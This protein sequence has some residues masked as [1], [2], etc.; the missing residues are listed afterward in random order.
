MQAF[1][2]PAQSCS[3][4][5]GSDVTNR[6]HACLSMYDEMGPVCSSTVRRSRVTFHQYNDAHAEIVG[7][8]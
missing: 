8:P 3:L 7:H 2:T 4:L 6:D 5:G 1:A